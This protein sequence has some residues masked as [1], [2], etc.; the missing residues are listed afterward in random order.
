MNCLGTPFKQISFSKEVL[1]FL[2]SLSSLFTLAIFLIFN[3]FSFSIYKG[4]FLFVLLIENSSLDIFSIVFK[5]SVISV[6]FLLLCFLVFLILNLLFNCSDGVNTFS[7]VSDL[8]LI[9]SKGVIGFGVL[10]TVN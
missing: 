1:L 3:S 2:N 10:S 4:I 6:S 5:S 9:S 8:G 7:F